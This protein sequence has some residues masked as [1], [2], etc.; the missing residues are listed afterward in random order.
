MTILDDINN[1]DG[2]TWNQLFQERINE[3][4]SSKEFAQQFLIDLGIN[5]PDGTLTDNYK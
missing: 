5:N 2:K 3:I 4:C 1:S